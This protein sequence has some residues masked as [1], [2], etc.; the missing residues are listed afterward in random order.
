MQ[1]LARR[2][3]LLQEEKENV[4]RKEELNASLLPTTVELWQMPTHFLPVDKQVSCFLQKMK[5]IWL[6]SSTREKENLAAGV[7]QSINT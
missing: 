4:D 6:H 3:P 2:D 7:S 5:L 1:P